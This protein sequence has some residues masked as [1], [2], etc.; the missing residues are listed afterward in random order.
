MIYLKKYDLFLISENREKISKLVKPIIDDV[1]RAGKSLVGYVTKIN[2]KNEFIKWVRSKADIASGDRVIDIVSN[3]GKV[4]VTIGNR[5]KDPYLKNAIKEEIEVDNTTS[6]L[7][8]INNYNTILKSAGEK[9]IYFIEK[10]PNLTITHSPKLPG[11]DQGELCHV[12]SPQGGSMYLYS[13]VDEGK[14]YYYFQRFRWKDKFLAGKA[15]TI[16]INK[17]PKG[18]LVA[19]PYSLS[20]DSFHFYLR[21]VRDKRFSAKVDGYI[22]L[23]AEAFYKSKLPQFK[24]ILR[25]SQENDRT[26]ELQFKTQKMATKLKALIDEEISKAGLSEEFFCK[27]EQ[28]KNKDWVVEIPRIV[29]QKL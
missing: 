9:G 5:N 16:L 18:G 21:R 4:E 12:S 2:S 20:L 11:R 19:E 26:L 10:L 27:V 14:F 15:T 17:I 6:L 24:Q 8:F 28:V 13:Y 25:N 1:V 3:N 22:K 7:S 29:L 23:N